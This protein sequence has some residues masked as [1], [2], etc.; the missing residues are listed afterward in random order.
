MPKSPRLRI[1]GATYHVMAR[2][3][4]KGTIF[5]DDRD[6]H[7]FRQ[8]LSEA[9]ERYE[10]TVH[11]DCQMSSHFHLV[12]TTPHANI[13]EFMKHVD[14][15]YTQYFNWRH[16]QVG[17][18]LQGPFKSILI[19]TDNYLLV[20]AAYVVMNPVD[21]GIVTHPG[22]WKWSSYRATAGLDPVPTYLSLDLLDAVFPAATREESQQHYC[23]FIDGNYAPELWPAAPAVGSAR[24]RQTVRSFIG[25]K[26]YMASLPRS[27]RALFRPS[28]EEL[29][30]GM[31]SKRDRTALM[32]RAHVIHG[33]TMA[34]IA[35]ALRLHPASVSRIICK[36]RREGETR[37]RN[38]ENWDLAP[39]STVTS[40]DLT[41]ARR[42]G[43]FPPRRRRSHD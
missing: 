2:G 27:Y 21:A 28:L 23:A 43:S 41:R 8:I 33:Y 38:V 18:L 11:A 9:R 39:Y 22:L 17:H 36:L 40:L 16:E 10:V 34:E 19:D 20:A 24:F 15:V 14:G 25:E 7:R 5:T 42:R 13:S 26:L 32:Q 37:I 30:G 3:N 31:V 29:F 35:R 4:R 1:R 12:V 6:R